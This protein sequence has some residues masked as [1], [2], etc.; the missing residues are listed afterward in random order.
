M[1]DEEE[2]AARLRRL[3]AKGHGKCLEAIKLEPDRDERSRKLYAYVA[4]RPNITQRRQAKRLIAVLEKE[5][6]VL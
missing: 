6:S 5:T 4:E 1:T 3:V 2:R